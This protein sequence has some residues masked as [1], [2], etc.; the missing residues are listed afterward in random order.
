MTDRKKPSAGICS[1]FAW[2]TMMSVIMHWHF[3]TF[4][5]CLPLKVEKGKKVKGMLMITCKSPQKNPRH[6]CWCWKSGE[7][8]KSVHFLTSPHWSLSKTRCLLSPPYFKTVWHV[9]MERVVPWQSSLEVKIS[10][11]FG[12][13]FFMLIPGFPRLHFPHL[14]SYAGKQTDHR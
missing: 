11:H 9:L 14:Q 1:F 10:D 13:V 2:I 4:F 8:K 7:G 3:P 12:H 6:G 5:F